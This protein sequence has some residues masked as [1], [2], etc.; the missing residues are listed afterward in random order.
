M[1]QKMK[2]SIAKGR[3]IKYKMYSVYMLICVKWWT[4]SGN[5]MILLLTQLV[6]LFP[7]GSKLGQ[8]CFGKKRDLA[9]VNRVNHT[10]NHVI[11]SCILLEAG[12][13]RQERCGGAKLKDK[14]ST[15]RFIC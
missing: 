13:V 5:N 4:H 8:H 3:L 6:G 14:Q 1:Q 10:V 7:D 2:H 12:S 15:D 11:Q 9:G